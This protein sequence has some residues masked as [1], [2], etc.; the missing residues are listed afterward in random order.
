M[1][2]CKVTIT[3]TADGRENTIVRDGEME[4]SAS[5]ITLIYREPSASVRMRV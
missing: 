1:K 5:K 4:L 3:T 2:A